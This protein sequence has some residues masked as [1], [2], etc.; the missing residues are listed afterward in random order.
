MTQAHDEGYPGIAHDL[1]T[2]RADN[3]RLRALLATAQDLRPELLRDFG[4]VPGP[5]LD[6][7]NKSRAALKGE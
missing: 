7:C 3:E 4:Y 1:E 2:L 6:F 5:V